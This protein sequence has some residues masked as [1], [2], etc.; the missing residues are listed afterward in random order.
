MGTQPR[1][2]DYPDQTAFPGAHVTLP[3]EWL[4]EH[5][6]ARDVAVAAAEHFNSLQITRACVALCLADEWGGIPGL[7]GSNPA[8]WEFGKV[9]AILLIWLERTVVDDFAQVYAIPKAS[10]EPSSG[11]STATATAATTAG[12]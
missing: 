5:F 7:T 1:R 9:P 10:A 11:G 8:A 12:N 6:M 3:A 4:G 2:V